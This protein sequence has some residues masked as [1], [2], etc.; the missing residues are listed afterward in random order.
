MRLEDPSWL[1]EQAKR[2]RF[3][4]ATTK[5]DQAANTLR[6]MARDYE[7]KAAEISGPPV[8]VERN[9]PRTG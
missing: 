9:T 8:T 5:D 6:L 7:H 3:L 2:C 1:R 4:A